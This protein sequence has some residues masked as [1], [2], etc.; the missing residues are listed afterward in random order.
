[1][2]LELVDGAVRGETLS[3]GPLVYDRVR[4]VDILLVER[5]NAVMRVNLLGLTLYSRGAPLT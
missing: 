5:R 2:V 4:G 1:M 3:E